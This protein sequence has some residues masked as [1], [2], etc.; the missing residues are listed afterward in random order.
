MQF[1]RKKDAIS[2]Q[3]ALHGIRVL[4]GVSINN[5]FMNNYRNADVSLFFRQG[6]YGHCTTDVENMDISQTIIN[7][8]AYLVY[9]VCCF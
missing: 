1:M 7:L 2:A 9:D 6:L 4:P 5:H 3:N 8:R